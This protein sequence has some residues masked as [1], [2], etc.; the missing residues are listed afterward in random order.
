MARNEAGSVINRISED[1]RS[2]KL[3]H[4]YVLF[5]EEAYLK[6]QFKRQLTEALMPENPSM[7]VVEMV[8]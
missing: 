4:L 1:I 3:E 6:D 7:P 8:V 2:G 5:G